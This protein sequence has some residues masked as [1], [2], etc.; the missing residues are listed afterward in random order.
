MIYELQ[1]RSKAE[2]LFEGTEDTMIR[3]CLQGVMDGRILVTDPEAPK[4]AMACLADF[5]FYAGEPNEELAAARPKGPV[6]MVPCGEGWAELLLKCW[7]TAA[8]YTRYSIRKDTKFDRAKLE[9]LAA[10]LP[11][12]YEMKRIDG[13]LYCRCLENGLFADCVSHFASVEEYLSLGRGFAVVRD[14]AVVSAASSYTVYREGI[15]IEIDTAEEERRKGLASAVGARL[16]LSCLDDGL[17][18]SWDAANMGSVRLAEKLGYELDR[19][20]ACYWLDGTD[21]NGGK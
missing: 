14:G 12:G 1:N 20:Y 15:E 17:Y 6:C 5:A 19:E 4:S 8:V 11:D 10:S 3:S 16:I 18:P 13:E 7:P 9:E 2:R 21:D